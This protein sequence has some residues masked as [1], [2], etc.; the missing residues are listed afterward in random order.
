MH[1]AKTGKLNKRYMELKAFKEQLTSA[2]ESI[3]FADTMA[4]VEQNYNFTP[5][6]FEN[7]DTVNGAD[8]NNGSCK[9]FAFAKI[10]NFSKEETLACFGKF[11]TV[12][13]LRNPE[14]EDHQNIRNFMI[15]GWEGIEFKGE[16]LTA[17]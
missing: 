15:Y 10:Q 2:P 4:V 16:A 1:L 6:E 12:D 9:L 17:K 7:G 8:Q 5:T 14:G 3:E 11:Y 13:V